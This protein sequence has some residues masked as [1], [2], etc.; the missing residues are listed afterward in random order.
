VGWDDVYPK[1][2]FQGEINGSTFWHLVEKSV[3]AGGALKDVF[4]SLHTGGNRISIV[5]MSPSN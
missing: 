3:F 5:S 1:D 2:R 4:P